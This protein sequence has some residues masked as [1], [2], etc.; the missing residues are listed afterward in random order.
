MSLRGGHFPIT[1]GRIL[2]VAADNATR[3]C[4]FD[5]APVISTSENA[6]AVD[7]RQPVPPDEFP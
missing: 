4:H 6:L 2:D 5:V 7:G 3:A 1:R